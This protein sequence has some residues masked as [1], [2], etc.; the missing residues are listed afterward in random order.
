MTKVVESEF[1]NIN[2]VNATRPVP[3]RRPTGRGRRM[4]RRAGFRLWALSAA[5]LL[6]GAVACGDEE[7]E[8]G[9]ED[10]D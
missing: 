4:S 2:R 6:L 8:D 9:E 3:V 1:M 10:D 7:E 5:A